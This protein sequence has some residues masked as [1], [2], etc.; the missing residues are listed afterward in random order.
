MGS[1]DINNYYNPNPSEA[2]F[3]RAADPSAPTEAIEDVVNEKKGQTTAPK[4]DT[5]WKTQDVGLNHIHQANTLILP[6]KNFKIFLAI[7]TLP[8]DAA[9]FKKWACNNLA[10]QIELN[11]LSYIEERLVKER[12]KS[13]QQA[14]ED[15]KKE[16]ISHQML[17]G[18]I[19][20][21]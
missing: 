5:E 16:D 4:N 3:T 2:T 21:A 15:L 18:R 20:A 13:D 9:S 11:E 17:R 12:E 10:H 1:G 8:I 6:S 7:S 14:R 19:D